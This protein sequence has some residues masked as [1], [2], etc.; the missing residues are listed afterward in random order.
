MD[1]LQKGRQGSHGYYKRF[2]KKRDAQVDND[3]IQ[4]VLP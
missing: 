2:Q 3:N 1:R 4:T